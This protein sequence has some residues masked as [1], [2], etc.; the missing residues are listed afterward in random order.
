MPDKVDLT[1]TSENH[2]HI[3][4]TMKEEKNMHTQIFLP[5]LSN[6]PLYHL[7]C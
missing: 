5:Q 6:L 2:R 1:E 3:C 4:H 7:L